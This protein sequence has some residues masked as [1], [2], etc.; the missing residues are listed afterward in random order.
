MK[1]T[2][3]WSALL[4][5]I[6]TAI[7]GTLF[8]SDAFAKQNKQRR[9][10]SKSGAALTTDITTAAQAATL[11]P[12]SP[13]Y[14]PGNFTFS[15]PLALTHA[16]IQAVSPCPLPT[17]CPAIK[18]QDTE[19]EIKTDLFGNVYV[20]AIHGYPGGVDLWKSTDKGA[21]FAYLGIPDGTEDKCVTGVT[22]CIAGARGGDDSI[23]VSSGG[24]LYISSLLPSS[25]TISVS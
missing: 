3:R 9:T 1:T 14:V 7:L 21:T 25:V 24:Y 22:P 5:V 2:V 8:L 13:T 17:G 12:A 6:I 4:V 18:D 16:P 20:T 15:S 19:P 23:D 11:S 10:S